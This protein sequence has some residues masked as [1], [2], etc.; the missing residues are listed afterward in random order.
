VNYSQG[1]EQQHIL[2]HAGSSGRFL[3]VGAWNA[4]KLS[5]TRALYELP[6]KGWAGVLVEPSPEPFAGLLRAYKDDPRIVLV[7][8]AVG[9]EPGMAKFHASS[10]ALTTSVEE[11]FEKWKTTGGFYGTFHSPVVTIEYLAQLFGTFDFVSIDTEGTSV[12][13]FRSLIRSS[14]RPKCICVEHDN[15]NVECLTLAK[16]RGYRE[17]YFSGENQ[18]F[19]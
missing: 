7:C 10:D 9:A 4:E 15:R 1:E 12:D 5:N 19:A 3:D 18:V 16:E 2:A 13:I 6:W 11:N 17:V 14:M 8:A